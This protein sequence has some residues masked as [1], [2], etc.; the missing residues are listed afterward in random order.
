MITLQKGTSIA[1][2]A[3]GTVNWINLA[4]GTMTNQALCHTR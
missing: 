4:D 3:V 1:V 2:C